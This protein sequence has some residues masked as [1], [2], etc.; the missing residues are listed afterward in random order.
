MLVIIIPFGIIIFRLFKEKCW[1]LFAKILFV[2]NYVVYII[3]IG[4]FVYWGFYNVFS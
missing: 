1:S 2:L 3:L 4:L